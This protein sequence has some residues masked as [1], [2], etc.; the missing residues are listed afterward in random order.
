VLILGVFFN[1]VR[2]S[3][4]VM[5]LMFVLFYGLRVLC[6]M[7][8]VSFLLV[9]VFL[10]IRLFLVLYVVYISWV[11]VD[12]LIVYFFVNLLSSFFLLWGSVFL[13]EVYFLLG[14]F[15]KM[16]FFPFM[17]WFPYLVDRL[18]YMML[19]FLGGVVKLVPVFLFFNG[20]VSVGVGVFFVV[21]MTVAVRLGEM[22]V[23]LN[24]L[25]VYL[26]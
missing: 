18:G 10:E 5:V 22:F 1:V 6:I 3:R 14:L 11:G 25:K 13:L 19:F 24:N 9:Y 8:S 16:G 26:V 7:T 15:I 21:F 17:W 2:F 20:V 12:C 4:F 23:V